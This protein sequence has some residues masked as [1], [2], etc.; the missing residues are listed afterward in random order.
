MRE[1]GSRRAELVGIAGLPALVG[2]LA[3]AAIAHGRRLPWHA[4]AHS[5]QP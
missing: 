4:Y 5:Q 1:W 2:V 3:R